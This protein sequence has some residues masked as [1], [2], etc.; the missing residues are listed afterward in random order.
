MLPLSRAM[1]FVIKLSCHILGSQVAALVLFQF[2][3]ATTLS[4]GTRIKGFIVCFV[5]GVSLSV[6]VSLVLLYT[7]RVVS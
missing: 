5:L 6:L 4:W 1:A 3:D 2:S 7:D